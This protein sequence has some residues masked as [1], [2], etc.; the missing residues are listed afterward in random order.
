M[1]VHKIL[2]NKNVPPSG[3]DMPVA[4][5]QLLTTNIL[6]PV[7]RAVLLNVGTAVFYAGHKD[8]QSA[9]HFDKKACEIV[10]DLIL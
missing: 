1:D 9:K 4:L 7:S 2:L 6:E 8:T 10:R 3:V 5:F